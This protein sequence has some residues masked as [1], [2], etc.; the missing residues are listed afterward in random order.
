M[1]SAVGGQPHS[2]AIFFLAKLIRFRQILLDFSKIKILHL[3]THLRHSQTHP[4]FYGYVNIKLY[5]F[6]LIF[7]YTPG[8]VVHFCHNIS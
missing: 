5:F 6:L 8:G 7:V 3:Q 2:L 1:S 4:I